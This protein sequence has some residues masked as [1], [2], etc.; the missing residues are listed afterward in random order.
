MSLAGWLWVGGSGWVA[1]ATADSDGWPLGGWLAGFACL[2]LGLC[3]LRKRCGS[4]RGRYQ[5]LLL[6]TPKMK[7][8]FE[9]DGGDGRTN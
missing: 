8:P 9:G 7:N 5:H 4:E 1:L 6:F 2:D 3:D